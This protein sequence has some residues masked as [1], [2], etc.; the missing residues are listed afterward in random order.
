MNLPKP[1]LNK[2][3]FFKPALHYIS[4]PPTSTQSTPRERDPSIDETPPRFPSNRVMGRHVPHESDSSAGL[5]L[6]NDI[7]LIDFSRTPS[8]I[9]YRARSPRI[10]TQS[11]DED[12]DL[13]IPLSL[14]PLVGTHTDSGGRRKS[15]WK[16]GELGAFLFGTWVGWQVYVGFLV[17]YIGAVGYT[18]VLLNR[19]ILWSKLANNFYL[20]A[21]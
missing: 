12:A 17:L 20:L 19:F 10:A 15:Y 1:L 13:D 21:K 14:R 9:P 4:I 6:D 16:S 5:D 11:E 3:S 8:P 7:P 2:A 18:L